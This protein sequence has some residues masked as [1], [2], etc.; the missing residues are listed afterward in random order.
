MQQQD[1]TQLQHADNQATVIAAALNYEAC[2]CLSLLAKPCN[3]C[4]HPS[5]HVKQLQ[6]KSSAAAAGEHE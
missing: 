3:W 1:E 5:A 4:C 6:L 2:G